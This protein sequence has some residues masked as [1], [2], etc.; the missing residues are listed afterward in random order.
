M[1]K[2]KTIYKYNDKEL[3]TDD[4]GVH[5]VESVRA[6]YATAYPELANSTYTVTLADKEKGTPRVIVFAKKVGTKGSDSMDELLGALKDLKPHSTHGFTLLKQLSDGEFD[7]AGLMAHSQAIETA[8]TE[9]DT[10]AYNS[11]MVLRRCLLIKPSI[12]G[13]VPIG[14]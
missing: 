10:L 3:F 8:A 1:E 11:E 13:K 14:F 5:T 12:V 2:E 4:N 7:T 9:L 6:H